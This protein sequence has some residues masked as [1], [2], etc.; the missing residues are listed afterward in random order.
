M[1][2]ISAING[3]ITMVTINFECSKNDYDR[4]ITNVDRSQ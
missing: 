2:I 4:I 3:K 1:I